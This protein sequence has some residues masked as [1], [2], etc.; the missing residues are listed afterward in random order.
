MTEGSTGMTEGSMGMTEGSMG[1]TEGSMGLREGAAGLT[2]SGLVAVSPNTM[3]IR[4]LGA[5][6]TRFRIHAT[7]S[8]QH[9]EQ[10][11]PASTIPIR[12]TP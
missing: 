10:S 2:V 5:A 6:L 1:M 9:G 8:S 4:A 3:T 12:E 7:M 11:T